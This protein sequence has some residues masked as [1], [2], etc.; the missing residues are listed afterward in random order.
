MTMETPEYDASARAW[1]LNVNAGYAAELVR[2]TYGVK[3]TADAL[4]PA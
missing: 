4:A 1:E 3:F 2:S